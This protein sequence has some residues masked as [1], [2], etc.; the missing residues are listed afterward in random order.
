MT[1][2]LPYIVDT[3]EKF[4]LKHEI[5]RFDSGAIMVDI[6]VN[7]SFHVIQIDKESIGLSLIT[8]DTMPFDIIPD[9]SFSDEIQFK[10]E[11][12]KILPQHQ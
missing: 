1:H 10:K 7:D 8:K 12:V 9:L 2:L 4:S 6:W 5:H 3:N 11:F